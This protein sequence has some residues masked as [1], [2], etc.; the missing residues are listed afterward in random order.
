MQN[1]QQIQPRAPINLVE[2]DPNQPRKHFDRDKLEELADSIRE[3]DIITPLI[4]RPHPTKNS[5]HMMIIE[6]ERRWRAAKIVGLKDVP[7]VV[8]ED[9]D[10]QL[11]LEL[12][13]IANGQRDDLQPLEEAETFQRLKDN[14]GH[15]PET[16][17]A[18]IGKSTSHVYGRLRLVKLSP[19]VRKLVAAG[20]LSVMIAGLAATIPVHKV[21]EQYVDHVLGTWQDTGTGEDPVE[22]AGIEPEEVG[23]K[24]EP[25]YT[26]EG[27]RQPLSFRAAQALLHRKYS[28]RLALA[29]FP[30]ADALLNPEAGPCTTCPKRSGSQPELFPDLSKPEDV[31]LDPGCFEKKT[32]AVWTQ[33]K[34]EAKGRGLEVVEGDDAKGVFGFDG[35]TTRK[36]A[37]VDPDA[38]LPYDLQKSPGNGSKWSKLLGKKIDEVPRVLVQ[39]QSGAPRELLDKRKAVE[40]LRELGKIDK[41]AKSTSGSSSGSNAKTWEERHKDEEKKREFNLGVVTRCLDLLVPLAAEDPGKKELAIW[42]WIARCVLEDEYQ[43][44]LVRERRGIKKEGELIA[45]ADK[46]K[47]L[48]DIRALLVECFAC[49]TGSG[50]ARTYADK[51]D[52]EAFA[53]ICKLFAVDQDKA[54]QAAKE[55][56][57][58]EAKSDAAKAD[59]KA[60][61]KKG[62]RK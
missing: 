16:I 8:R 51:D 18:K 30:V 3:H 34:L 44:D 57:K 4:L 9:V 1:E 45:I 49:K 59:K 35:A 7:Y 13:L 41:P 28:T 14:Y 40:V 42:R 12:Q 21:Q 19:K 56:A 32:A 55:A 5:G 27:K 62:K 36:S 29:K 47:S 15:D 46:A 10:A 25:L 31:C 61:A 6:G 37:Y 23:D 48:D 26:Q 17:A 39:D 11:A 43:F 53:E 60:A 24:A 2:P 50:S 22:S 33:A 38:E 54:L 58:A 20:D 52:K